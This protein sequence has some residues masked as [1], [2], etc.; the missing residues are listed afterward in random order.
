MCKLRRLQNVSRRVPRRESGYLPVAKRTVRDLV[1]ISDNILLRGK[2]NA[3]CMRPMELLEVLSQFATLFVSNRSFIEFITPVLVESKCV[4]AYS[5]QMLTYFINCCS[6]LR[7][8]NAQLQQEA[9]RHLL[10]TNNSPRSK[11]ILT[12][13]LCVGIVVALYFWEAFSPDVSHLLIKKVPSQWF[14]SPLHA[15]YVTQYLRKSLGKHAARNYILPVTDIFSVFR[16]SPGKDIDAYSVKA[17]LTTIEELIRLD[18]IPPWVRQDVEDVV[19]HHRAKLGGNSVVRTLRIYIN[20]KLTGSV[21][22]SIVVA[23]ADIIAHELDRGDPR[24]VTTDSVGSLLAIDSNTVRSVICVSIIRA[25]RVLSNS[26]LLKT[27]TDV[28]G[29]HYIPF[30]YTTGAI[31]EVLIALSELLQQEYQNPEKLD[32]Q[33]VKTFV[34][35]LK[36]RSDLEIKN[37]ELDNLVLRIE[38]KILTEL[39]VPG[40]NGVFSEGSCEVLVAIASLLK[41]VSGKVRKL[42]VAIVNRH[43]MDVMIQRELAEADSFNEKSKPA[44]KIVQT[45]DPEV[46]DV[47]NLLGVTVSHE[48]T[49]KKTVVKGD[50]KIKMI[51]VE[52]LVSLLPYSK[53]FPWLESALR[54]SIT[55][56]SVPEFQALL[57]CFRHS[58]AVVT[59]ARCSELRSA[60]HNFRKKIE[61]SRRADNGLRPSTNTIWLKCG[62]YLHQMGISDPR[63]YSNIAY[64]VLSLCVGKRREEVLKILLLRDLVSFLR[65]VLFSSER[66]GAAAKGCATYSLSQIFVTKIVQP[67]ILGGC[68]GVTD[69]DAI[70][71]WSLTFRIMSLV[72]DWL[73]CPDVVSESSFLSDPVS[74]KLFIDGYKE[75]VTTRGFRNPMSRDCSNLLE[76]VMLSIRLLLKELFPIN[77]MSVL[78]LIS[79]FVRITPGSAFLAKLLRDNLVNSTIE[80]G[81][82]PTEAAGIILVLHQC[83]VHCDHTVF[84][85]MLDLCTEI[86]ASYDKETQRDLVE[87]SSFFTSP[88][89]TEVRND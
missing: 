78:L 76:R 23:C 62:G 40:Y 13:V 22:E 72:G 50:P 49:D 9:I 18:L 52:V 2:H 8:R 63:P 3:L 31:K 66:D 57:K 64:I 68:I 30:L 1:R 60:L 56:C 7:I 46:K 86:L 16:L 42:L 75:L 69:R 4:E 34:Q 27:L 73:P 51:S 21:R 48:L 53:D 85:E 36:L 26:L 38:G 59:P 5:P 87:A 67:L 88:Q 79:D 61:S 32:L 77:D 81:P 12:D 29:S 14:K 24:M 43:H 47:M 6:T 83:K 41:H 54:H 39:V 11:I 82:S 71:A 25:T 10:R 58:E 84:R 45:T 19:L 15:C 44:Q 65:G 35:V 33:R 20:N 89:P 80:L 74:L 37:A 28:R 70:T 55:T 17:F